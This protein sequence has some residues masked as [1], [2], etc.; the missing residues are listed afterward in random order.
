MKEEKGIA[1]IT[2]II[3]IIIMTFVVAG[4]AAV[5]TSLYSNINDLDVDT[6]GAVG[7]AKFNMYM[8]NDI[9]NNDVKILSHSDNQFLLQIV[10]SS[11]REENVSYSVSGETLYRNSV[12]I[13]DNVK[14][15]EVTQSS[16]ENEITVSLKID[17]YE[18]TTTYVLEKQTAEN[19]Y[20]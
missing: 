14:K 2:L 1:L 18:K 20:V 12:K 11:D 4:V 6:K 7:F 13:C 15:I 9:K 17:N 19:S 3:Y 8:I 10:H 5:T 16:K